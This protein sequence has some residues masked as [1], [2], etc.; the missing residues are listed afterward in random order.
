[1]DA[2]LRYKEHMARAAAKGLSAAMC[3]RRLKML[4]PQ[5]AR[6]LV[7]VTVASTVWAHACV[8]NKRTELA[9]QSAEGRCPS[10]H[11]RLPNNSDCGGGSRDKHPRNRGAPCSS[12]Y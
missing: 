6:Q 1:M 3:L 12:L 5:T 9:E 10:D 7:T 11:R 4:S 8:R 2:K